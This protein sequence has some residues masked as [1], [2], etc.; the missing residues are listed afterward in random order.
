MPSKDVSLINLCKQSLLVVQAKTPA[1]ERTGNNR[2]R[3]SATENAP[4]NFDALS[5]SGPKTAKKA[6][7]SFF[8]HVF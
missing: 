1:K 2:I 5:V 4:A 3:A 8:P 7:S 6:S